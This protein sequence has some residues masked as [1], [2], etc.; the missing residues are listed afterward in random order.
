M[1]RRFIIKHAFIQRR[2]WEFMV[3]IYLSI[4]LVATSRYF[5]WSPFQSS[6]FIFRTFTPRSNT[7]LCCSHM[8]ETWP[9]LE[10]REYLYYPSTSVLLCNIFFD[11]R[12][13]KKIERNA[14]WAKVSENRDDRH[15]GMEKTKT[16]R[17]QRN[18]SN[19]NEVVGVENQANWAHSHHTHAVWYAVVC[20]MSN[21][22]NE[23]SSA[24]KLC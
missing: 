3:H 10:G 21:G 14:K 19:E 7:F 9:I 23:K 2:E 6:T 4:Y 12:K 24:I 13:L 5:I 17:T 22:S 1:T 18:E 16:E 15:G 20:G 11:I 8:F